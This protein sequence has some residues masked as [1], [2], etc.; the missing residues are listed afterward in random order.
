MNRR[1]FLTRSTVTAA[2]V[3]LAA[4]G[5]A[6]DPTDDDPVVGRGVTT[7]TEATGKV[8]PA[9]STPERAATVEEFYAAL[10]AALDSGADMPY[11]KADAEQVEA[12]TD[13]LDAAGWTV[14]TFDD[15]NTN[16]GGIWVKHPD[17]RSFRFVR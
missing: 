11:T 3:G 14:I 5:C 4:A 10:N 15:T 8:G 17:G 16:T 2:A 13:A 1:T 9:T 6:N 12:L 7:T